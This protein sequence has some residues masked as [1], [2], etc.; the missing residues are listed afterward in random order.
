MGPPRRSSEQRRVELAEAALDIIAKRGIA[1]L[2]TRALAEHVGLTTGAL[3][4]HFPSLDE[5]L[6]AVVA[7]VDTVLEQTYPP[8]ELPAAERL[9]RFV[10]ARS[11]AVGMRRGILGLVL[12]EQFRLALP[13]SG[14]RRL[15]AAVRRTREFISETLAEAQRA[16]DVRDDTPAEALT[17]IVVGTVLALALAPGAPVGPAASGAVRDALE[18]LLRPQEA[19]PGERRPRPRSA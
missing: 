7:R 5:L 18:R 14:S 13:P 17:E 9:W 10:E 6:I 1:A 11:A 15:A 19:A 4:R 3:F 12:S 8:P 2:T 16:G